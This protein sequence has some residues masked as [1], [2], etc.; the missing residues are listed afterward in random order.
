MYGTIVQLEWCSIPVNVAGN[1]E[2]WDVLRLPELDNVVVAVL[3]GAN[4]QVLAAHLSLNLIIHT[5]SLL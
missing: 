2:Y 5:Y 3:V 4:L 1:N